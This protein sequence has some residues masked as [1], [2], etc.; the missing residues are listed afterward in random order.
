MAGAA[1]GLGRAFVERLRGRCEVA[2]LG[3]TELDITRRNDVFDAVREHKP[4]LIIDAAGMSDIDNC[5]S[6][7]W[8]AY[9]VNRDGAKHLAMAAAE[10]GAIMI[11]PSSDLVFD[12]SKISPYREEEPPNPL[13]IY[14]DTKLAA[15]LAV[16]SHAPRHLVIRTGWLF[17]PYGRNFISDA[18][19]WKQTQDIV[20]AGEDHRSQPTYQPD[21]VDAVLELVKQDRTGLWHVASEGEA[22]QYEASVLAFE[23]LRVVG[24]EVKALRRGAGGR[25]ALRPRY[26][27]LNCTKLHDAGIKLRSWKDALEAFLK[28]K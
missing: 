13:S 12:G 2:A 16:M 10:V 26:S 1:G 17:G 27:V 24:C 18:L 14:G 6:D 7:R 4:D 9:L 23:L 19:Q 25:T 3:H 5:E 8:Q 15:E 22:T 28:P 21:F 11:F 20:L